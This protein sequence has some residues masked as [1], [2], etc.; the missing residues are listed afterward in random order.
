MDPDVLTVRPDVTLDVVLRYLRA[1]GE[2]PDVFDKMIVVA[3][4]LFQLTASAMRTTREPHVVINRV[5]IDNRRLAKH[6]RMFAMRL[7]A[8]IG[9]VL[10][11]LVR[12]RLG[13]IPLTTP[14]QFRFEFGNTRIALIQLPTQQSNVL[15]Q[16]LN[17]SP[18]FIHDP[19]SLPS[20]PICGKTNCLTVTLQVLQ[21]P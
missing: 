6:T 3:T 19:R 20:N 9:G 12:V 17:L 16:F 21:Y 13:A 18:Q 2:L 4:R 5:L 15:H 10:R 1:R 7:L 11:L 8:A 14:L